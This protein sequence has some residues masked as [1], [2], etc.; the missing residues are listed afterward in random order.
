MTIA[1]TSPLILLHQMSKTTQG[2]R[3]DSGPGHVYA[4]PIL[5]GGIHPM[6]RCVG[7]KRLV[8]LRDSPWPDIRRIPV[9]ARPGAHCQELLSCVVVAICLWRLAFLI[10]GLISQL[11]LGLAVN[12]GNVSGA[13]AANAAGATFLW[14]I[15]VALVV[16]FGSIVGPWMISK[17][18]V[19]GSSGVTELMFGAGYAGIRAAQIGSSMA[20][21]GAAGAVSNYVGGSNGMPSPMF[22]RGLAAHYARRPTS[23]RPP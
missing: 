6:V 9:G 8:L 19:A 23:S 12:S 17:R 5:H 21:S 18:F 1:S 15:C 10:T 3:A 4:R 7:A 2:W 22:S 13:G 20:S 14:L 16:I 11:L